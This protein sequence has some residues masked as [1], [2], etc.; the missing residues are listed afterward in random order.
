MISG[1]QHLSQYHYWPTEQG[2]QGSHFRKTV[3]HASPVATGQPHTLVRQSEKLVPVILHRCF[4]AH[5]CKLS[6]TSNHPPVSIP[7]TMWTT[8]LVHIL[9][10]KDFAGVYIM[11]V[12]SNVY[13]YYYHT[14]PASWHIMTHY[15]VVVHYVCRWNCQPFSGCLFP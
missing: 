12:T 13:H 6:E 10:H 9:T 11:R 14:M 8:I 2:W 15:K 1:H 4:L 7:L 3:L 5:M